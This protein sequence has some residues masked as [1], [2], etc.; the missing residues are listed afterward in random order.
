MPLPFTSITACVTV[1]EPLVTI[2][3][4]E[5]GKRTCV[6]K[7]LVLV[8]VNVKSTLVWPATTVGIEP[9]SGV[10]AR[11]ATFATV[12]VTVLETTE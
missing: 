7:L 10:M 12:T 9:P 6:A 5:A 3:A 2:A 1:T 4:P 11:P 8:T